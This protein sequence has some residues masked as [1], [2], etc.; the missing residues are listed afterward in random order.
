VAV[1]L[2]IGGMELISVLYDEARPD[3]PSH[4]L[5]RGDHPR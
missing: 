5:D 3:R 1:A 4:H 2:I